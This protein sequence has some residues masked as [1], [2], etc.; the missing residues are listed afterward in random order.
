MK[1]KHGFLLRDV[2]VSG[3]LFF[4]IIALFIILVAN[5]ANVYDRSDIIDSRFSN[6]FNKLYTMTEGENGVDVTR[7]SISN[8]EGLQLQGNFDIAFSSTWTVFTLVWSTIDL[9]ASMGANFISMFTFIDAT[10][11]KIV[12]YVFVSILVTIT[13]FNIISSVLRGRI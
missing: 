13:M 12:F 2:V 8:P 3:L 7:G 1:S 11:I 6:N 4:G 10:V 9:Y 5:A